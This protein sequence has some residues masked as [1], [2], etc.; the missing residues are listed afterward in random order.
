MVNNEKELKEVLT[1][2]DNEGILSNTILGSY[3]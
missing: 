3:A 1:V 2:L